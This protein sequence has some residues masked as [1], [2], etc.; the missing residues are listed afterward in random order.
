MNEIQKR[1]D[2]LFERI[3]QL[4]EIAR[5]RVKTTVDITMV[6]TYYGIGKYI[7][8][9]EQHGE[10]RAEYGAQILKGLSVKLTKR[11]C[12][13]WSVETLKKCR[14]FF[15]TYRNSSIG[16]TVSTKFVAESNPDKL[17][18]QRGKDCQF[19]QIK[20][21]WVFRDIFA[22]FAANYNDIYC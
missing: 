4:I 7:V 22:T 10:E 18:L 19:R 14:F 12:A 11:F 3:S 8:D 1:E 9:D 13:G 16:S 20:R 17:G 21:K 6:Y 5:T 15:K 2:A